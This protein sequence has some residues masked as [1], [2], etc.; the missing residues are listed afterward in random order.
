MG[1]ILLIWGVQEEVLHLAVELIIT[2]A[3]K[4]DLTIRI[5]LVRSIKSLLCFKGI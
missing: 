2:I 1:A 4:K 5:Y 3:L